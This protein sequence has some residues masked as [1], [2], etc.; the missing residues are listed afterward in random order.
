[1]ALAPGPRVQPLHPRPGAVLVHD[2]P[3]EAVLSALAE[4][5]FADLP[6]LEPS[7]ARAREQLAGDLDAALRHLR[8][9]RDSYWEHDW[10]NEHRGPGRHPEHELW[11]AVEGYLDILNATGP[12]SPGP[13][14]GE[15]GG[16]TSAPGC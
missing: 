6:R 3:D 8:E 7:P 11:E 14:A 13:G 10:R 2:G 1:M 15:P 12:P 16:T 5:R 9:V 4:R